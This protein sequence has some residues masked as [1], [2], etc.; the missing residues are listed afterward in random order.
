MIYGYARVSS[1]EQNL[2]RQLDTFKTQKITNIFT[3]KQS[4]KD[5]NRPE[6]QRLLEVLQAGDTL[7]ICSLDRLSRN[8]E[9]IMHLWQQIEDKKAYIKVLDMPLLD[10]SNKQNGLTGELISKIVLQ[11]LAYVAQ[12]EREQIKER[13]RQGIEAAMRKGV[14][15]GRPIA[16][17][18]YQFEFWYNKVMEGEISIS[19][20]SRDMKIARSTFYKLKEMYIQP[21]SL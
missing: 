20:A 8:F 18:K 13:Q 17:S 5:T 21:L 19:Q 7:A 11:L 10:T 9:D 4:G 1:K 12:T 2:D 15:F 14:R 3:D 6:L 16:M